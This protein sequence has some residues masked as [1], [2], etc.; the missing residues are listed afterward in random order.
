ML[1]K[2][3]QKTSQTNK[4]KTSDI[5]SRQNYLSLKTFLPEKTNILQDLT[6]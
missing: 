5:P 1:K 2:K 3:T 6:Q 4:T